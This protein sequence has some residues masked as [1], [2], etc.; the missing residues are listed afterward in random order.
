MKRFTWKPSTVQK[1]KFSIKDFF[2][3]CFFSK[4]FLQIGSH[5]LQK[6]PMKNF[7]FCLLQG[8]MGNVNWENF[9]FHCSKFDGKHRRISLQL[10]NICHLIGWIEYNINR[11]AFFYLNDVLLGGNTCFS[12]KDFFSKCDQIGK[13]CLIS[14]RQCVW[15]FVSVS[16]RQRI[17]HIITLMLVI[18]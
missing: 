15:Y 17:G 14:T 7:I 6:S 13:K 8:R 5:L 10:K 4:N 9:W 2:I 16:N 12:I 1:M 11:I 3:K 18:H